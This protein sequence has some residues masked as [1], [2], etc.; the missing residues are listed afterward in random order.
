MGSTR[1]F[2]SLI[3]PVFFLGLFGCRQAVTS[4]TLDSKGNGAK[5][6]QPE[7]VMNN[8][9]IQSYNESG[10]AWEMVSPKAQGTTSRHRMW[11]EPMKV[12]LYKNG[13]PSTTIDSD[14]GIMNSAS[15]K[16]PANNIDVDGNVLEPGDMFLSGHVVVISTEGTTLKTDW[17]LFHQRTN[18]I[19]STA[20]VQVIREDSVT[21]GIGLESTADMQHV[22]IFN[23][24]VV[25]KETE[26]Q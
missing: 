18:L 16:I 22:K 24:T 23:Q 13:Q 8:A 11:A 25:I 9:R 20:P 6:Q 10:L 3:I 1:Q 26:I 21:N 7:L 2:T 5:G 19:T 12:T 14:R 17:L 4:K 15:E